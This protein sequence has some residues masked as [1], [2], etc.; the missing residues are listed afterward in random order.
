MNKLPHSRKNTIFPL[1]G[2]TC[3][4]SSVGGFQ[5]LAAPG[6]SFFRVG[7]FSAAPVTHQDQGFRNEAWI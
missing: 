1:N 3:E 6:I 7:G 5:Y 4:W 2:L